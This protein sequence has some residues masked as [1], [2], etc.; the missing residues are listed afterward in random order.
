LRYSVFSLLLDLDDLPLL[1]RGLCLFAYNGWGLFSFRDSDHGDGVQPLRN[2]V[3]GCLSRARIDADGGA[4]RILC[5]PRIL[6]YAFNPL[7]VFFCHSRDGAL[8]AIL[9]EVSNTHGERHT[10]VIPVGASDT[11]TVH[12]WCRK[13]FFVSPFIPMNCA[14]E[15]KV[16]PPGERVSIV[17]EEQDE[18]GLLLVAAFS[19]VRRSLN[20]AAL[21][22]AFFAYPL[23]TIK[24]IAA[25]HFEAVR[26]LF[27]RA[28]VFSHTRAK[29]RFAVSIASPSTLNKP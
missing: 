4:I 6:G 7:T 29:Q 20:D 22:R 18:D 2:W 15:F 26:L 9:Y 28:P 21:L 5:Y 10:Y 12:Q 1:G 23:M 3:Q 13:E 11:P 27:K 14:Y 19:G 16:A 24:I 8:K 25:I 17:I